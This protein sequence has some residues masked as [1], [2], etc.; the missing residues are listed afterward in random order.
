M[1]P[2]SC[3]ERP[4]SLKPF[5]RSVEVIIRL[6]VGGG[7]HD[8]LTDTATDLAA[9]GDADAQLKRGEE[10]AKT[11]TKLEKGRPASEAV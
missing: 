7:G 5:F 9:S 4:S 2:A 10:G 11:G 1:R 3:R 8:E 6:E